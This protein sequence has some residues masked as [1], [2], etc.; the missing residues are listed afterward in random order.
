V[1]LKVL[2]ESMAKIRYQLLDFARFD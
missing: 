2:A 1:P